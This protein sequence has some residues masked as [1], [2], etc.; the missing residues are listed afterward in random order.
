MD[1]ADSRLRPRNPR[2]TGSSMIAKQLRTTIDQFARFAHAIAKELRH[3]N[4]ARM[5]SAM[6][7]KMPPRA[8][9]RIVK[10]SL[11]EHHNN[12]TRCC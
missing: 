6:L 10:T 2:P 1:Q 12:P 4:N 8:R 9:T 5:D 11:R 7:A 3:L